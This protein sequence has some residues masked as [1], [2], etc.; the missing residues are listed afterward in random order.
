MARQVSLQLY[1]I[2]VHVTPNGW[3][4]TCTAEQ[5]LVEST[6]EGSLKAT[7]CS[8]MEYENSPL[9]LQ[10]DHK[11]HPLE[12]KNNGKVCQCGPFLISYHT[13]VL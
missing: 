1:G 2:Q 11:H 5:F 9:L 10:T 6:G 12:W 8:F 13:K 4:S 7:K 3:V